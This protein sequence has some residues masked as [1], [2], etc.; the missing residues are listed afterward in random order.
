MR[1]FDF[2]CRN[3]HKHEHFVPN[4]ANE[5]TCKDCGEV[6]RKV[7]CAPAFK[8]EGWSGAFPGAAMKWERDHELRAKK[9]PLE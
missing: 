3:G 5:V 8:L 4:E 9:K 2:E 7:V 6:A 1:V